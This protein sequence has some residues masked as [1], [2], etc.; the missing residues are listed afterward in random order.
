MGFDLHGSSSEQCLFLTSA[1]EIRVFHN[2]GVVHET[3][4]VFRRKICTYT[5]VSENLAHSYTFFKKG[6]IIYLAALKREFILH[7]HTYYIIYRELPP[8]PPPPRNTRQTLIPLQLFAQFVE[9]TVKRRPWHSEVFLPLIIITCIETVCPIAI[10]SSTT[11]CQI[12]LHL[13]S[14][15][16]TASLGAIYHL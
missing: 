13:L 1:I 8:P 16:A 2:T 14:N 12:V 9:E 3:R 15:A 6:F 10:C 4:R 5:W 11:L 7:A